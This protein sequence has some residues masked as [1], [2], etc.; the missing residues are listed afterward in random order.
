[1]YGSHMAERAVVERSIFAASGRPG[2]ESS[3][4]AL[5]GAL[6]RYDELTFADILNDPNMAPMPDKIG[7]HTRM[8]KVYGL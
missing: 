1:M 4:F 3:L 5:N 6:G 2:G 7:C 8:E